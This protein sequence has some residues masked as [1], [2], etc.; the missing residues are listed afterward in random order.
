[1]VGG[2]R[3]RDY[4]WGEKATLVQGNSICTDWGGTAAIPNGWIGVYV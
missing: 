2:I 3:I 4:V 1:M